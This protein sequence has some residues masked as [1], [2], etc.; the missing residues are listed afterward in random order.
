MHRFAL[1]IAGWLFATSPANAKGVTI[2]GFVTHV[3]S[4]TSF[5]IDGFKV[6]R[7]NT[8]LFNLNPE[9][10]DKS[11][12]AFKPEDIR[13]GTELE[14]K[15][16]CQGP[17]LFRLR[18]RRVK[19]ALEDVSDRSEPADARIHCEGWGKLHSSTSERSA[20]G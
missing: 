5:E 10:G 11:L 19:D 2:H 16:E 7:D 6:T 14:I 1:A 18:S 4:P 15:G 20:G 3:K 12:A 8:L 13:V 9:E 17:R